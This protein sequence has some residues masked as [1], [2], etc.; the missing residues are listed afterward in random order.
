[1]GNV[2]K[3]PEKVAVL[4]AGNAFRKEQIDAF[5]AGALLRWRTEIVNRIIPENTD[6]IKEC[7]RLH[8]PA[9]PFSDLD[10]K[11]W[12]P[13]DALRKYLAKDTLANKSLFTRIREAVES[14]DYDAVSKLQVEMADKMAELKAT[15]HHYKR[16]IIEG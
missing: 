2:A 6:I 15:Y 8:D 12:E 4:T 5:V 14:G 16:N 10:Q 1:M 7:K 3:Y 13:I 9:D 11:V